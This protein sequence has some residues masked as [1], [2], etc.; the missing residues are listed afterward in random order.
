VD[1]DSRSTN[2]LIVVLYVY[3]FS[4]HTHTYVLY[5]VV[6][7]D[8]EQEGCAQNRNNSVKQGATYR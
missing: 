3:M 7:C 5:L 1:L 4:Y 6:K 2:A 8:D